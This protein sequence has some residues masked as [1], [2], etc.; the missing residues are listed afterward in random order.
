MKDRPAGTGPVLTNT[1][2]AGS[3]RTTG[4]VRG[5]AP[6]RPQPRTRGVL[7]QVNDVLTDYSDHWPLTIR[8]VFYRLVGRFAF[9]KT[10]NDYARLCEY[11]NRG[12]RA[13]MV[14]WQ[15]IRDDGVTKTIPYFTS[16]DPKTWLS[17]NMPRPD[18]Y[19][20]NPQDGQPV[21]LELW[22]EA[23]GMVPML[24][25]VV[26]EYGAPVF[27]FGG[28]GSVT[29][30]RDAAQRTTRRDVPTRV[31]HAGDYDPSGVTI[32]ESAAADVL[33]FGGNA[34]FERIALLPEQIHA[35]DLPTA[36]PKKNDK[37]SAF[38]DDRTVQLESMDPADVAQVLRDA[39]AVTWD[40]EAAA[41]VQLRQTQ[42]REQIAAAIDDLVGGDE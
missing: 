13:G 30:L 11:L 8:Q 34:V 2:S 3:D 5:Y 22:C 4:R 14:P 37:R 21:H 28:F 40:D 38:S 1:I 42:A 6:W 26:E 7:A 17:W 31:L 9:P 24:S 29:A 20:L 16:D 25:R 15:A 10:E 23:A 12:R 36:P 27:S 32:F 19:V 39:V 18:Q 35:F 33:A 41:D